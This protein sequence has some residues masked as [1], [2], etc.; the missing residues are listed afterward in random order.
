M[1]PY[2][3]RENTGFEKSSKSIGTD[4]CSHNMVSL[5]AYF[6]GSKSGLFVDAKGGLD[7]VCACVCERRMNGTHHALHPV[8]LMSYGM[9]LFPISIAGI[10]MNTFH[11]ASSF[12]LPPS[13]LQLS[14]SYTRALK[15]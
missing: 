2:T 1:F 7:Y 12:R 13:L 4:G 8:C 3:D 14:P 11:A 6:S 5:L 15:R 9:Y 10:S